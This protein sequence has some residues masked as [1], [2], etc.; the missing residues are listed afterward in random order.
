MSE[1]RKK[2]IGAVLWMAAIAAIVCVAV[3]GCPVSALADDSAS[4][5]RVIVVACSDYQYPNDDRYGVGYTGNDGSAYIV[6]T[7]AGHMISDGISEV[8]GFICAGD[9]DY[10]LYRREDCTHDGI[11]SL[12]NALT[13]SQLIN[14][15]TQ[16]VMV[17]GNHDPAST[18]GGTI[19][20]GPNDPPSHAYGVFVINERDFLWGYSQGNAEQRARA[21]ADRLNDYCNAKIAAH[22]TAPVFVISHVPLHYTMRTRN[23]G[24]GEYARYI[25]DVLNSASARGL[26]IIYL[27]GH[28]HSNG[29]DDYL[30]GSKVYLEPG[31]N[32]NIANGRNKCSEEEL[33]FVYMNAGFT[34]YYERKNDENGSTG[35]TSYDIHDLSMTCFIITG[36]KV[37]IARYDI[38][39][40]TDLKKA[41]VYNYT[42]N[43]NNLASYTPNTEVVSGTQEVIIS[44]IC[45]EHMTWRVDENG[46]LVISGFGDMYDYTSDY[47]PWRWNKAIHRIILEKGVTGIG[48]FAFYDC[49]NV[50][51][52]VLY[53]TVT[54]IGSMAFENCGLLNEV[55]FVGTELDR[56]DT[57]AGDAGGLLNNA[58]WHVIAYE[59]SDHYTMADV[60][61]RDWTRQEESYVTASLPV[62]FIEAY[63][64]S[65]AVNGR[66][67][68]G[69]VDTAEDDIFGSH[70]VELFFSQ[71]NVLKLPEDLETIETEAF[72]GAECEVVLIP[73]DCTLEEA[74]FA[75]CDQLVYV[76]APGMDPDAADAAF[77]NC[78][79]FVLDTWDGQ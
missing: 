12:T 68:F 53:N 9:Y 67:L 23:N 16:K 59:F 34:G 43:E 29:W 74:A 39:G 21:I 2:W 30:G 25:F 73:E 11:E 44:N 49:V 71:L 52:L 65:S 77:A 70:K 26:N 13:G 14:D 54:D 35:T 20:S 48:D 27:Y 6:S 8:D 62:S 75:G 5:G 7:I 31:D 79:Y 38:D 19:E 28:D 3:N 15:D 17:Q 69:T 1:S 46:A 61:M 76:Y 18:G 78:G 56:E 66:L 57:P 72:T 47:A 51:D 41:G 63:D 36:D 50:R 24:D 33:N 60:S 40:Q 37:E 42:W 58:E 55:Y 45:G 10:D 32:I 4:E 64:P 22:F